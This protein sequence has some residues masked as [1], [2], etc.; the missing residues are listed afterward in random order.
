M[1][2]DHQKIREAGEKMGRRDRVVNVAC[3]KRKNALR[4]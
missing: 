4:D 3:L 1:E 2:I